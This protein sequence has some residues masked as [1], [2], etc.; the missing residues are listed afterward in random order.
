MRIARLQLA[1]GSSTHACAHADGTYTLL[2]G[3]I[4]TSYS[5][6]G[7][8]VEGK[9]LAPIDPRAIL[10][11][12]LNY[13]KHAEETKAELPKFPVLFM[14]APNATQNPEDPIRLP[15]QLRSETV[16]Y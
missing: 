14:K 11:I 12:G 10:C 6:T 1:G 7:V 9:L 8:K 4:F 2:E 15:R 3:D 13:R 16:D 5:D